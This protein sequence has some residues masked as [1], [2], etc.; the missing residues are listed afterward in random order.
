MSLPIRRYINLKVILVQVETLRPGYT[1][2]HKINNV[3]IVTPAN[4]NIEAAEKG[5]LLGVVAT[6]NKAEE[7]ALNVAPIFNEFQQAG[8]NFQQIATELNNRNI[9]YCIWKNGLLVSVSRKE[10]R[11]TAETSDF[12]NTILI[13]KRNF[14]WWV[15]FE[16]P[17][18]YYYLCGSAAIKF[19][20]FCILFASSPMI[21]IIF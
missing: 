6:K 12:A 9:S 15:S 17:L 2:R 11:N 5:R 10:Y 21:L 3:L 20:Q 14:K 7:L 19:S 4:L 1:D 13:V 8:Y 16:S 18:F